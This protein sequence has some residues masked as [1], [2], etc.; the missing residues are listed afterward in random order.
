MR[1]GSVKMIGRPHVV[2]PSTG[3]AVE[4]TFGAAMELLSDRLEPA[5]VSTGD[6]LSVR[7]R[8][9]SAAAMSQAYK[10]FVH[11]LD[12][13]GEHVVAQRD[14]QPQDGKAPTPSWVVGEVVDDEYVITLPASLPGGEYPIEVGVYDARSGERLK[15]AN[16]DNRLVLATR[17]RVQ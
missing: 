17:L 10:V 15:L 12:P 13:G 16:G 3:G 2:D 6:R 9:R 1:L 7:L 4:A 11:V 14:A 5:Q 8:W